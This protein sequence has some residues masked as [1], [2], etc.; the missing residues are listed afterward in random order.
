MLN[1]RVRHLNPAS[2]GALLA[3]DARF[4]TGLANDDPVVTW[5][6]RTGTAINPTQADNAMRPL[7]RV[8][9]QGGLPAVFFV[10]SSLSNLGFSATASSAALTL[11]CTLKKTANPAALAYLLTGGSFGPIVDAPVVSAGMAINNTGDGGDTRGATSATGDLGTTFHVA[12]WKVSQ[13]F[14]DGVQTA[15]I[16]TGTVTATGAF[17][18]IGGR[19]SGVVNFDGYVG[20]MS[21]WLT[22]LSDA[23]RRRFEQSNG[24]IWRLPVS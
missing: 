13:L 16:L 12:T 5:N 21:L 11:I 2:A 8:N 19:T 18:L 4:I 22:S 9:Q 1:R 23:L 3:V 6:G 14:K 15:Y 20:S 10:N 7:Y 24:Y 17:T